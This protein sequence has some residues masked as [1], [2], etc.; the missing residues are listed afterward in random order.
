MRPSS[1]QPSTG[2]IHGFT[3]IELLVVIAIIAVLAALIF[4]AMTAATES[5]HQSQCVSNLRQIHVAIQCYLAD[6]GNQL[7]RRFGSP[8]PAEGY[9]EILMPYIDPGL[10]TAKSPT[11]RKIFTCPS[12]PQRNIQDYPTQPGYGLN[13]FYDST[14]VNMVVRASQTILVA[15]VAGDYGRGSHRADRN[16][17]QGDNVG[18][19]DD[20][21]HQG[22]AHY[23]FFDGH[24]SKLTF[25][26]TEVPLDPSDPG[27]ID[28]WGT[29]YDQH[30]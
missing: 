10:T 8:I 1:S 27:K 25:A 16:W 13:W 15:E 24:V 23:L 28:M 30:D 4:P 3:L 29:N 2:C 20:T 7:M 14:S 12:E 22:K 21:R 11:A 6:H 26:E 17:A 19:I 9:D 18:K 5:S